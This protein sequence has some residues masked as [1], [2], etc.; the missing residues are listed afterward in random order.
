MS[1]D[2]YQVGVGTDRQMSEQLALAVVRIREM[3]LRGELAPGQRVAETPLAE[4]LGVS[5]TPVRQAIPLLAQE[6]LLTE[7]ETRGYRVRSFTVAD[8]IDAI[9]LRGLL[10]GMA[11]RRV[12]EQGA[13]KALLRDLHAC[14]EDGDAI[15]GKRCIEAGDEGLY[16]EMNARFHTVI[17]HEASSPILD[18]ALERIGRVSFA[19]PQ[20]LAFDKT[21]LDQMY[22][23]LTYAHRQHHAVVEALER[24]ES[25]RVEA[26]MREHAN[27]AKKSINIGQLRLLPA[28]GPRSIAL[29]C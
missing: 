23:M 26:L 27:T 13:S 15:L 8:V 1:H 7:H 14:L 16:A 12:A 21:H 22:D 19:G 17:L 25:A 24:G 20:A 5:R 6:G 28:V 10:E 11:A 18:E 2:V 4:R 9:D 3:I 29:A